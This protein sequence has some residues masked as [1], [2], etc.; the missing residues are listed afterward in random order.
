M[1][2]IHEPKYGPIEIPRST[3]P[4]EPGFLLRGQDTLAPI[5]VDIYARLA[6]AAAEG[7]AAAGDPERVGRLHEIANRALAVAE[8]IREWQETEPNVVRLP[9]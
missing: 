6:F 7:A 2:T 4:G 5:M 9:D 3:Q 1:G 8:A